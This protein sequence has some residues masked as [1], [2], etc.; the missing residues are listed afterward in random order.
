MNVLVL[1]AT[2]LEIA[3]STSFLRKNKVDV[4]ITGIG[5]LSATYALTKVLW[6]KKPRYIIQAG[7]A[8]SF[9]KNIPLGAV[10]AVS[11]D[12]IADL[13]VMEQQHWRSVFDLGLMR[14]NQP[15]F[16][17]GCLFNPYKKLLKSWGLPQVSAVTV[18]EIS[19][20]KKRIALL[21]ERG[22]VLESMEGAALHYVAKLEKI[23]F[24]QMRAVSNYVGERNK[25]KWD[26]K[27]SLARLNE[28]L[29]RIIGVLKDGVI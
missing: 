8:G 5:M 27:M 24:L 16:I 7:L 3:A 22:A 20:N 14:A 18:N 6:Q 2:K 9:D 26:F 13:G 4:L 25:E 17:N 29:V 28:E 12:G 11:K 21:K 19:T 10:L 15:P 1:S 23:P